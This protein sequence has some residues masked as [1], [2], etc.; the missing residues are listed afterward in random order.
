MIA[1]LALTSGALRFGENTVL[2][3]TDARSSVFPDVD[4]QSYG[5]VSDAVQLS[6]CSIT[7]GQRSLACTGS[8]GKNFS[9][10]A[11]G[12]LIIVQGAGPTVANTDNSLVTTIASCTNDTTVQLNASASATVRGTGTATFGTDN[13]T[14]FCKATQCTQA[15]YTGIFANGVLAGR[16]LYLPGGAYLTSQPLYCRSNLTC[17]GAGQ[18]ATQVILA[19]MSN[20]LPGP[21]HGVN[22]NTPHITPTI[23]LGN[24]TA[25]IGTC[26]ADGAGATGGYGVYD[27]V[28]SNVGAQTVGVFGNAVV[29]PI[30][31]KI[32]T[33]TY[34]GIATYLA[35]QVGIH[36]E[37]CDTSQVC[38]ALIGDGSPTPARAYGYQ[39]TDSACGDRPYCLWTDGVQDVIA[40]N[41]N[42]QNYTYGWWNY[43]PQ[44][45]SSYRIM[46]N[47]NDFT[48]TSGLLPK[49]WIQFDAPCID[50]SILSNQFAFSGGADITLGSGASGT[51]NLLVGENHFSRSKGTSVAASNRALGSWIAEGNVWDTP[52]QYAVF[53]GNINVKFDNNTCVNPFAVLGPVGGGANA[54]ENGCFFFTGSTPSTVEASNNSATSSG[55]TRYPVLSFF[56][57][58]VTGHTSGNLSDYSGCAVCVNNTNSGVLI[59]WN[60]RSQNFGSSGDGA[61][62]AKFDPVA[63]VTIIPG[64]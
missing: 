41:I 50:C 12:K 19:S 40:S 4:V 54:Y 8:H 52:G 55:R 57:N 27:L 43:S 37:V 9:N 22:F 30:L 21:I 14:A 59:S 36:E 38:V 17:I 39:F 24:A 64:R 28:V 26:S 18:G 10:C 48:G 56:N 5:A 51:T 31:D 53:S 47:G 29:T 62:L 2:A 11:P 15:I 1:V 45:Y 60:E 7:I 42:G 23:C 3:A 13:A 32:W 46:W 20:P 25:G 16:E 35:L 61:F 44:G 34:Y 58:T 49:S 33:Q 6:G 63:G